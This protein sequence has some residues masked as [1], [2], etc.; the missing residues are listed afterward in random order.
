MS[1]YYIRPGRFSDL[2]A[3]SELY[4]KSFGKEPLLDFIFPSRQEDP[5]SFHLWIA[6]KFEDRWWT[7]GWTFTMLLQRDEK[8]TERPLGFTW[9]ERPHETLTF[10]EKWLSPCKLR[11]PAGGG[12][13]AN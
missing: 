4:T 3:A 8:G 7:P 10:R 11:N 9:W 5:G 2:S 12:G 13:R 1:N 6:R